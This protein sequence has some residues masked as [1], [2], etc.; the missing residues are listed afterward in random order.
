M[1]NPKPNHLKKFFNKNIVKKIIKL[2]LR[3]TINI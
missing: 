1:V 3:I 2:L